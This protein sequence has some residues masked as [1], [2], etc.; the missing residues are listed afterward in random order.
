MSEPQP[1]IT[2]SDLMAFTDGQLGP[3][4]RAEVERWLQ[5]H[6]EDAARVA[7]WRRVNAELKGALDA[8]AEE[9]VPAALSRLTTRRRLALRWD[10]AAAA[11]VSLAIG[12]G[13]GWLIWGDRPGQQQQRAI[14]KAGLSIHRVYSGE[15]R[16]PVEVFRDEETHLINWLSRRLGAQLKAPDL[17]GL[18]LSLVGGR[19]VP[20]NGKPGAMLMYEDGSG[21][22][23]TLL[24]VRSQTP[25]TTAF[26]YEQDGNLGAFYWVDDE[27][28]YVLAGQRDRE[29]LMQIAR[30]VYDQLI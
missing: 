16:H 5:S 22:R 2:E 23:Y 6:P 1:V 8:V 9:P 28:S 7:S 14:A 12:L 15:V 19:L 24:I 27:V 21:Q 20:D 18:G 26:R 3:E 10:M 29:R 11:A 17:S 25:R 30:A 13:A 4:R